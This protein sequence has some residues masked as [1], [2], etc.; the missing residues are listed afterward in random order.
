MVTPETIQVGEKTGFEVAHIKF[1]DEVLFKAIHQLETDSA[2]GALIYP[3]DLKLR[4]AELAKR[5]GDQKP[6]T[7][8]VYQGLKKF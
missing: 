3:E 5:F 7:V 4:I 8:T 6:R 2:T 1:M